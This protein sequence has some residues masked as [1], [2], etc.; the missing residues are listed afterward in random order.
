MDSLERQKRYALRPLLLIPYVSG[1]VFLV[2]ILFLVSF[3]GSAPTGS[4]AVEISEFIRFFV[5]P[6]LLQMALS[7]LV[8]GKVSEGRLSGGFKHVFIL[9]ILS[10][11]AMRTVPRMGT[12]L[13]QA[14]R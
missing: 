10:M 1:L 5:P 2:S 12:F 7:G 8:A 11:I 9:S 3:M 4:S 14:L 6:L 13:F